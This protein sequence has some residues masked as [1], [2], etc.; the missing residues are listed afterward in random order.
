MPSEVKSVVY[1]LA[2]EI[3]LYVYFLLVVNVRLAFVSL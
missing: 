1:F 2:F 3:T